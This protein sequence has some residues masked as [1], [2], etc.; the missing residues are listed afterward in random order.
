MIVRS[1]L[2]WSETATVA[3]RSR[4]AGALARAFLVSDLSETERADALVA[5]AVLLDDPSPLVRRELA[6]A[7]ALS[8][9]APHHIV[10][11]LAA[12]Q[13]DV[14]LPILQHSPVLEDG[15]LIDIV[16]G[17]CAEAQ[18][19]IAR[20]AGLTAPLRAVLAEIG[21]RE[22]VLTIIDAHL[23][24]AVLARLIDRFADDGEI[25]EAIL[26][27]SELP[28]DLRVRLVEATA[29]ALASFVAGWIPQERL[30]RVKREAC[31]RGAVIIA[32]DSDYQV[33]DLC[34]LVRH[35][36]DGRQL[37]AAL[38][39]RSLLSGDRLL[40]EAALSELSGFSAERVAGLTRL[41]KGAG[42][43]ALFARSGLPDWLIVP[44]KAALDVFDELGIEDSYGHTGAL[45]LSVVEP[46]LAA[47]EAR[48]DPALRPVIATLR[49]FQAEAAREEARQ[50]AMTMTPIV[51]PDLAAIAQPVQVR[52]PIA[53]DLKAI[54]DELFCNAA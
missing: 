14:A 25:R 22:A 37:T 3:Q 32:S 41:W 52:P 1:F 40:L 46:V 51:R 54:E 29:T 6:V 4:A 9:A 49:R 2:A 20:R 43:R 38:L 18:V 10:A 7:L 34:A 33:E 35:L 12:D 8:D 47:C 26:Q 31:E 30:T 27:L 13:F 28:A 23:P 44:I 36:R 5:M 15:D 45:R 16:V 11:S 17:G 19:V 24:D 48:H 21:C 39:L 50:R 42:F 53:I